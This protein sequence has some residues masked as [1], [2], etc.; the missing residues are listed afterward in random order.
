MADNSG[1][2]A[3]KGVY[4]YRCSNRLVRNA[5]VIAF[6]DYPGRRLLHPSK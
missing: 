5:K 6:E 3:E 1:I 2:D 4:R